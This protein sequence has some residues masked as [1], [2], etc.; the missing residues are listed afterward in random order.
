MTV[1]WIKI[2]TNL[3]DDEK[4]KLIEAMP[5][6]D[7]VLIIW[8][9]LLIQ[10]GK[11][12]E[13]GDIILTK[14]VPYSVEMLST[15]F[16]RPLQT[17]K[18][19]IKILLD[20]CLIEMSDSN[21]ISISNWEKHQNVEGMDRLKE[22]NRLRQAKHREQKRLNTAK[23]R[24]KSNVT[25]TLSN[26]IDID[27]DIDKE[28]DILKDYTFFQNAWNYF[29]SNYNLSN[30][31][32]LTKK[33]IAKLKIRTKEELFDFEQILRNAENQKFLLG[34]NKSNWEVTFD[35][36]IENESNYIKILEGNYERTH[37]QSNTTISESELRDFSESIL[38]DSRFK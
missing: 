21:V 37:K 15:I 1:S 32:S 23:K 8:F 26:A 25:V 2:K 38:K 3:F 31:K 10:A 30:I 11:C 20:L 9:K 34:D 7:T 27:K 12:N 17:V 35:W 4:I 22:Q 29:A 24:N 28:K 14:T 13:F 18:Y 6:A 16:N 33:R 19:G 5:E 36:I